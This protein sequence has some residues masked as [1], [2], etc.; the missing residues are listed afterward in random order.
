MGTVFEAKHTGTE[1]LVALK[2]L[3]EELACEESALERFEREAKAADEPATITV[4][5]QRRDREGHDVT[6]PTPQQSPPE[7]PIPPADSPVSS[8]GEMP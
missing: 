2:F 5:M 3:R 4:R 6:A 1:R 8:F 7:S